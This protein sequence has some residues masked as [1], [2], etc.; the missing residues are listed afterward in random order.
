MIDTRDLDA[1]IIEHRIRVERANRTGALRSIHA[2]PTKRWSS[3]WPTVAP[4]A[5]L[6]QT[7][8]QTVGPAIGVRLL[9]MQ[10]MLHLKRRP[11]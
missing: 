3:R 8:G 10:T 7:V 6:G 1:R 5:S 4:F 9:K 2:V 11:S